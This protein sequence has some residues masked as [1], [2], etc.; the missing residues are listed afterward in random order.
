M[1]TL[2]THIA[3]CGGGFCRYTSYSSLNS[4]DSVAGCVDV[5]YC[6]IEVHFCRSGVRVK[7]V[8]ISF[9]STV[10]RCTVLEHFYN[11]LRLVTSFISG[12]R[13]SSTGIKG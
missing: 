10:F 4:V 11:G 1:A 12:S 6:L 2:L 9:Y 3:G 5:V 8:F 13:R 7:V